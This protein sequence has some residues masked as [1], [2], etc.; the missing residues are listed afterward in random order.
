M[1]SSKIRNPI[2]LE[3]KRLEISYE[4]W[5]D[6]QI[7]DKLKLP[8]LLSSC[9]FRTTGDATN[10]SEST[11]G[12][13]IISPFSLRGVASWPGR[14]R[15]SLQVWCTGHTLCSRENWDSETWSPC[16]VEPCQTNPL[17][18]MA[19]IQQ[20]KIISLPPTIA[21][22][23]RYRLLFNN[24]EVSR[25]C[26]KGES[27]LFRKALTRVLKARS[28]IIKNLKQ[29][30][31][32]CPPKNFKVAVHTCDVLW[33]KKLIKT[34]SYASLTTSSIVTLFNPIELWSIAMHCGG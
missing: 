8:F 1:C 16:E 18:Y 13:R 3:Q 27:E 12:R 14:G 29:G 5:K 22:R 24:Q 30:D 17:F 11:S 15:R 19:E 33:H 20:E 9:R 31:R 7:L 28:G 23:E 26:N 21:C 2:C 6:I 10:S 4:P 32:R 25:Y 34:Q